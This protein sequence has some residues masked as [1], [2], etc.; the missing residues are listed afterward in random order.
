[1]TDT[2]TFDAVAR[3]TLPARVET[4]TYDPLPPGRVETSTS[5]AP[6]PWR[7]DTPTYDALA[8]ARADTPTYDALA[9][10]RDAHERGVA[11][12]P[13]QREGA[14]ILAMEPVAS[15]RHRKASPFA[16]SR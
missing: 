15:G 2:P 9:H 13:E 7:A 5:D 10:T 6:P 11:R 4:P 14:D 1:M 3:D 16:V 12:C 8:P